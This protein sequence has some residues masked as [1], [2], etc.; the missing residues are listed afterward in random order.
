MGILGGVVRPVM[1]M[2]SKTAKAQKVKSVK[3]KV[4]FDK[5]KQKPDSKGD[6]S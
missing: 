3:L 5:D 6:A 2:A 4:K 1:D